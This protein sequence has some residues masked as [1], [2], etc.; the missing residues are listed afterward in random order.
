MKVI[1]L[2]SNGVLDTHDNMDEINYNNLQR[3]KCVVNETNAKV[4]ISSSLKN[5]YYYTGHLSKHLQEIIKQI[6]NEGIEVIDITPK[7]KTREEE[8]ELYLHEH[9]E[10]ENFCIIYDDYEMNNLKDNLVK[11]P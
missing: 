1:F 2:D 6:E 3:L 8:I 7:A 4:V 9:P 11:L 10:I 5:S